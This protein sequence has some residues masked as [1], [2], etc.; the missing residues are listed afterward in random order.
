MTDSGLPEGMDLVIPVAK[1]I[2]AALLS[3]AFGGLAWF[4]IHSV[5]QN[6]VHAWVAAGFCTI[7]AGICLKIL[8]NDDLECEDIPRQV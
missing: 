5:N 6:T 4:V 2:G 8:A 1:I 3:L 7:A